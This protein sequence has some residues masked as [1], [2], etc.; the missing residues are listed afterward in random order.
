VQ[1][2]SDG[3]PTERGGDVPKPD[4]KH[5]YT[6]SCLHLASQ[7]EMGGQCYTQAPRRCSVPVGELG[8]N[9]QPLTDPGTCVRRKAARLCGVRSRVRVLF[10]ATHGVPL[11]ALVPVSL[12]RLEHPSSNRHPIQCHPNESPT[13]WLAALPRKLDSRRSMR[14]G[15]PSS[16]AF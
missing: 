12:L 10:G 6:T 8:G 2:T 4:A 15:K 13:Q 16:S 1:Q 9:H 11:H 5:T 3:I 14:R 7:R